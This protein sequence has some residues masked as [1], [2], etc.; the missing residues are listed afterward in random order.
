MARSVYADPFGAYINAYN[1][2]TTAEQN[3]QQN[4]RAARDSDFKHY[5]LDPLTLQHAQ[6]ENTFEQAA[7]KPR[8]D[9]L[10]IGVA[11]A[12]AN[13]FATQLAA[14]NPLN[15]LGITEPTNRA[16]SQ[17]PGVGGYT[18]DNMGNVQFTTDGGAPMGQPI[19]NAML[20]DAVPANRAEQRAV[21]NDD[22]TRQRYGQ[23]D[24]N[25]YNLAQVAAQRAETA[26]TTAN[27]YAF[28]IY[29]RA[30]PSAAPGGLITSEFGG[31]APAA[32]LPVAPATPTPPTTVPT[33]ANPQAQQAGDYQAILQ[34]LQ[35]GANPQ[36]LQGMFSQGATPQQ[37]LQMYGQPR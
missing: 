25:N 33:P 9:L 32:A 2:G 31:A 34:L 19:N 21:A 1:T 28:D 14:Y 4:T 30:N 36:Q 20:L 23:I 35:L 12:Q 18:T 10:P 29:G 7:L 27:A 6:R 13:S 26:Q 24:K 17:V 15:F 11:N 22:F 3:L 5:N 8:M 37:I 16:I